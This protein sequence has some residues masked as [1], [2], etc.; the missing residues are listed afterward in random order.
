MAAATFGE[1]LGPARERF[2]AATGSGAE[3]PGESVTAAARAVGKIAGIL[4][5]YLADIAPHSAAEAVIGAGLDGWT[6]VVLDAREALR[7]AAAGLGAHGALGNR[8]AASSAGSLVADL[9]AASD[10]LIAGR[11]LLRTH[12]GTDAAGQW[13]ERSDWAAVIGSVPVTRALVGEVADWSRQLAFLSVRLFLACAEN[14]DVS[15]PVHHGLAGACHWMLT[16][17]AAL[18]AGQQSSPAAAADVALLRAIPVNVVPPR[19]APAVG[20]TVAELAEGLAVSAARLRVIAWDAAGQAA[21]SPV[22]TADSWQWTATGAAVIC[23]LGE[24][25]LGAL[26]EH[27]EFEAG[28]P[29]G[30]ARARAAADRLG[31]ACGSWRAAATVWNDVVTETQGLTAPGIGDTGDLV[32]RVGRLVSGDPD[33]GPTAG[34]RGVV[35]DIAPGG[36]EFALMVGALHRAVDVLDRLGALDLHTVGAALRGGRVYVLTRTLPDGYD[37]PYRFAHATPTDASVLV[38]VYQAACRVTSLAVASLGALAVTMQ[39]PSGLLATARSAARPGLSAGRGRVP[40]PEPALPD[41]SAGHQHAAL[42]PT[43]PVARAVRRLCG[44]DPVLLLRATAL[45]MATHALTEEAKNRRRPAGTNRSGPNVVRS[46]VEIAA[47][48]FR[49][50]AASAGVDRRV[51][52]VLPRAGSAARRAGSYARLGLEHRQRH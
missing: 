19:R 43:G 16:A 9:E 41:S 52:S 17:S 39:A 28:L 24:R 33:W 2:D 25:M 14:R 5:R 40:H 45:D 12:V 8:P 13:T 26:A 6:R 31:R 11:D 32:V 48:N 3:L 21:W 30:R 47:L 1:L 38:G 49:P 27:P 4:S 15:E 50:N 35:R 29:G 18:I 44:E 36:A 37:V 46:Q 10:L 34:Q 51:N 20:E 7:I 22:M 42:F 23:H